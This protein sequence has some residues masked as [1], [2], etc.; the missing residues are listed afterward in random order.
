MESTTAESFASLDNNDA[1]D[2][3]QAQAG[4]K[5]SMYNYIAGSKH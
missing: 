2:G 1:Q 4:S 5:Q 3:E